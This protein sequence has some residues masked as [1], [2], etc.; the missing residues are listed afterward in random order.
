MMMS[1]MMIFR[2]WMLLVLLAGI[3]NVA[4]A[5]GLGE[6]V[7]ESELNQP[8]K[9]R[10]SLVKVGDLSEQQLLV[11]L[12]SAQDFADR[13]MTREFLY[14][15]IRFTLN[16][17][18]PAGPSVMLTTDALIKEP[19]LNLLVELSSPSG[20]LLRSYTLLLDNPKK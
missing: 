2:K 16:M 15:S 5:V 9:A 14:Q 10:I 7:L 11:K 1:G 13:N 3:G 12:A 19:S 8:L 6:I 20:R 17:K 18:H 4:N